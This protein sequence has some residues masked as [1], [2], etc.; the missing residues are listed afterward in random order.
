MDRLDGFGTACVA[1]VAVLKALP[2]LA[3]MLV[4]HG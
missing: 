3:V 1:M 4:G 2:M